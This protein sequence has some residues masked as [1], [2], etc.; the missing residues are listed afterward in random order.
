MINISTKSRYGLKAVLA[1]AEYEGKG[2]LQ[3][4][5]IARLKSIPR[6][7][8]EQIFNLLGKANIVRSVRGK[9]GG[10]RLARSSGEILASEVILLLEGG[11]EFVS[12][13]DDQ[14]EVIDG[15]LL[16]AEEQLLEAFSVS[17]E[18]LVA[19]QAQRRNVLFFDI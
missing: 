10:Y 14:D 2:L 3:I 8:L 18:E 7:Y 9:N 17:L 11:I 12:D 4:K 15:M 16:A 19:R 5:E 1:L 13:Q 6:Q